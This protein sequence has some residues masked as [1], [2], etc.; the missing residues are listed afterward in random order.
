MKPSELGY[1]SDEYLSFDPI[2]FA[3]SKDGIDWRSEFDNPELKGTYCYKAPDV[4]PAN[5]V[6]NLQKVAL[7]DGSRLLSTSY[8]T[9]ELKMEMI[10]IGM[11]EGDAMLAYDALQRFLISREAY[12]ICFAN[13]PQRMYYVRAKLAAPTFTNE[14]SWT[15]EVT[16]TDLIGL[17]RSVGTTQDTVYG[18]GNNLK[19]KPQYTFSTSKFTVYNGSNVLIDPE[20]RGHPFKMTFNGSSNG[21]L[22]ITNKTTGD[23]VHGT[24]DLKFNGSFVIDGVNPELNGEGCLLDLTKDDNVITLQIGDNDFEVENFTGTVSFDF[25]E[26]WLS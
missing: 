18:F 10:F 2:E 9:R 22:K 15:C 25:A 19:Q 6:D 17:S 16:F 7:M 26:W 11:D 23:F 21:N 12:W 13:W 14:K 5:P 24:S 1:D 3:I 8:G 4:Q 20:R